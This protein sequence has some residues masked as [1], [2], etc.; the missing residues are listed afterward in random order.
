MYKV[1]KSSCFGAHDESNTEAF[2][3]MEGK[4]T[5]FIGEDEASSGVQDAE[6]VLFK[7]L[8]S[9]SKPLL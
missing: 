2:C 9:I 5:G 4:T 1:N 7:G 3:F 6:D 8:E